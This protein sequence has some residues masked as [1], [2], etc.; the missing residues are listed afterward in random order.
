MIV[1][2]KKRPERVVFFRSMDISG[3]EESDIDPDVWGVFIKWK[4]LIKVWFSL[5]WMC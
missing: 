2:K 3:M 5:E 1:I 4:I